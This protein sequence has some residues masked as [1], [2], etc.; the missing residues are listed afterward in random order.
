MER[1]S[2]IHSHNTDNQEALIRH[3]ETQTN[4]WV[5]VLADTREL[6]NLALESIVAET[7]QFSHILVELSD[8]PTTPDGDFIRTKLEGR[9]P[10]NPD[11]VV[12]HLVGAEMGFLSEVAEGTDMRS[13]FPRTMETLSSWFA[14]RWVFWTDAFSDDYLQSGLHGQTGNFSA[15]FSFW[16]EKSEFADNPFPKLKNQITILKEEGRDEAEKNEY[17]LE[18]AAIWGKFRGWEKAKVYLDTVI[19][20]DVSSASQLAEAHRQ[21]GHNLYE[22]GNLP[23]ALPHLEY[24]LE[25][26][27]STHNPALFAKACHQKG[28]IHFQGGDYDLADEIWYQALE[29]FREAGDP[30]AVGQVY[31][32]R[33]RIQERVGDARKSIRAYTKSAEAYQEAGQPAAVAKAWQHIGAVYQGRRE[34]EEALSAFRQALTAAKESGDEFMQ[35]ALEDSIEQMAEVV[36]E[37]K[38]GE[39]KKKGFLGRLFG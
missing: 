8:A 9:V 32:D 27:D 38:K 39:D 1:A 6:R 36:A 31:H 21:L 33:A 5:K 11:Q 15:T 2:D 3:L 16:S 24:T 12:I 23:E 14:A 25:N 29:N 37:S 20:S 18:A 22:A 4:Q 34:W 10:G 35:I 19:S 17:R 7:G 26:F 13:E 30:A 28:E